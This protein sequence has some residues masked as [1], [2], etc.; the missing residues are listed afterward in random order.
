M[1]AHTEGFCVTGLVRCRWRVAWAAASAPATSAPGCS[2]ESYIF[3]AVRICSVLSLDGRPK[4]R[5][6]EWAGPQAGVGPFDDQLTLGQADPAATSPGHP[7]RGGSPAPSRATDDHPVIWRQRRR[8]SGHSRLSRGYGPEAKRPRRQ[9][10]HG[11][12]GADSAD[13]MVSPPV[14]LRR[15]RHTNE[16]DT[17]SG[18]SYATDRGP[19]GRRSLSP[20][21]VV[22]EG[23]AV[24]RG[25]RTTRGV[26]GAGRV[27]GCVRMG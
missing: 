24:S 25:Q 22:M 17:V 9:S 20:R 2:Y 7:R 14:C 6:R 15:H 19:G 23:T 13:G 16:E 1:P 3:C 12:I 8:G 26:D 5:P 10:R 11:R 21:S 4:S 18:L 27:S